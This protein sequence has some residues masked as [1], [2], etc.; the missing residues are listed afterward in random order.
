MIF[1][2]VLIILCNQCPEDLYVLARNCISVCPSTH[3]IVNNK[4]IGKE[5]YN[6]TNTLCAKGLINVKECREKCP[7]NKFLFNKRCQDICLNN[8]LIYKN[9]CVQTCPT[10]HTYTEPVNISILKWKSDYSKNWYLTSEKRDGNMC[11]SKCSNKYPLQINNFCVNKCTDEGPYSL[12]NKCVE[13]CPENKLTDIKTKQCVDNCANDRGYLN[14]SCHYN[15]PEKFR[16]IFDSRCVSKCPSSDPVALKEE[17]FICRKSCDGS[18]VFKDGECIYNFECKD[19][20][21]AFDGLCIHR[22]PEGFVWFDNC[23]NTM[24]A[25]TAIPVLVVLLALLFAAS[26][27]SLIDFVYVLRLLFVSKE[28]IKKKEEQLKQPRS[29]NKNETT[30]RDDEIPLQDFF[31]HTENYIN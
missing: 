28:M 23:K 19:P 3:L 17:R 8:T 20:M 29:R 7:E 12:D 22:C 10:S 2:V 6:C 5:Q 15:C 27:Q 1:V 11:V 25:K 4:I 26:R 21:F 18:K 14:K 13:N 31:L 24:P 16:Y 9:T 30:E